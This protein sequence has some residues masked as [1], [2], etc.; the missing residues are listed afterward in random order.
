MNQQGQKFGRLSPFV[1]AP[2][3]P[4]VVDRLHSSD[5]SVTRS[6]ESLLQSIGIARASLGGRDEV[7]SPLSDSWVVYACVTALSEA[8]RQVPLNIWASNETDAAE[9]ADTHPLRLLLNSPNPDQSL[10]DLLSAGIMHRK[11]SG[12]DWWFLM[13]ADG[14]PVTPSIDQRSSIP[15][16]TMIV[17]VSGDFVTDQ[18]DEATGRILRV[19][20]SAQSVNPPSFGMGSVVHFLD[21]NP[22]DPQRGLSAADVALRIVS[23]GFQT[24]RYQESVMRG[25]GPGAFLNYEDEMGNEEEARLQDSVNEAVKDPDVVGGFKVV[26]GKVRIIPNPATPK[27]MLQRETLD[28]V[29]DT[30]CAIFQV[31]PPVIGNYDTATYN[32][33]T[34][35]YRQFWASVRG[36]LDTVAEKINTHFIMRLEDPALAQ[37]RVSFDYSSIVPLQADNSAQ[38]RLAAELASKGV[39]LSFNDAA[40][41]VGLEVEP[42]DTASTV[43]QPMSSLPYAVNDAQGNAEAASPASLGA[44]PAPAPAV[45]VAPSKPASAMEGLNGAQVESLLL[46]V[47]QVASGALSTE[48]GVALINAAFPSISEEQARR[49]LVGASE[50]MVVEPTAQPAQRQQR[51]LDSAEA[52]RKANESVI[53]KRLDPGERR[54]ATD[55]LRW[56]RDYERAQLALIRKV[57]REGIDTSKAWTQAEV[58]QFLLLNETEWAEQLMELSSKH[59]ERMLAEGLEDAAAAVVNGVQLEVTDPRVVRVLAEQKAKLAEGVTSRLA[60]EV[61]DTLMKRLAQPTSIG[62]LQSDLQA[63]LPDLDDD[64]RRVFGNKETRALTIARTETTKA[65][66]TAQAEGYKANDIERIQWLSSN[67]AATRPS[68]LELD[69]EVREIGQPFKPNLRWPGDPEGEAG[70][71]INCRCTT[72][73]VVD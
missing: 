55:M 17:P 60:A 9:V 35:A 64:M 39:G 66:N 25:G 68:H 58:E 28:W 2:G 6:M 47:S 67:D 53:E 40:K 12:E 63:V 38:F 13:D 19:Q 56:F 5:G 16:P 71:V 33:V 44:A 4:F 65:Y 34:E 31:P 59:I 29:R 42:I 26:T 23:V 46:I 8:V 45:E 20:Y 52:R 14:K 15:L 21:Y 18:R 11:L 62:T 22:N 72:A 43:F 69:G 7:E 36:Y 30:V 1:R 57:A 73:P 70:E 41:L 51:M 37:C 48:S 27:E 32:N 54:M 10:S 3:S 24:E 50:T 49:I 61:R